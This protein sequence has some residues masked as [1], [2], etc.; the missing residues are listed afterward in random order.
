MTAHEGKQVA[1]LKFIRRENMKEQFSSSWSVL[2]N[3]LEGVGDQS[4]HY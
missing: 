4:R 3:T 2:L 1:D